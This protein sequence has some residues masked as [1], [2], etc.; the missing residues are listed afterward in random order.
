MSNKSEWGEVK[1]AARATKTAPIFH[2]ESIFTAICV[3][4]QHF[5]SCHRVARNQK[6][7]NWIPHLTALK[8]CDQSFLL[9][10]EHGFA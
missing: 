6:S 1:A 5:V 2:A 10:C 9:S 8:R 4:L 3:G 7:P